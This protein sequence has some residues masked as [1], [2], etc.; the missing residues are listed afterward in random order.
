[1]TPF[2]FLNNG[3]LVD[4]RKLH[5]DTV[6][7]RRRQPIH[8]GENFFEG[9]DELREIIVYFIRFMLLQSGNYIFSEFLAV[10]LLLIGF[11]ICGATRIRL[12]QFLKLSLIENVRVC[13]KICAGVQSLDRSLT[14]SS[15]TLERLV[16][17]PFFVQ[18]LFS[19]EDATL[20][21]TIM[22]TLLAPLCFLTRHKISVNLC[23]K[24]DLILGNFTSLF[25]KASL[26]RSPK[27][28]SIY[29]L[30]FSLS[31]LT[32]SLG[33]NKGINCNV[34]IVKELC[35]QTNYCFDQIVLQQISSDLALSAC[36]ISREQRRA[37]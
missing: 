34:R 10:N 5:R 8:I 12:L 9:N 13:S 30:N 1:M 22:L 35:W 27:I 36:C 26:Q 21:H 24:L 31:F 20:N 37:V 6:Q 15:T 3:G 28:C 23:D 14:D 16:N 18:E 7:A 4:L 33:K 32:F 19:V 25:A 17:R 2:V 29:K 11:F